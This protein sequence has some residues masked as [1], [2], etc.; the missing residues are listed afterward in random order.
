[1]NVRNFKKMAGCRNDKLVIFGKKTKLVPKQ[2]K[3][4]GYI[5]SYTVQELK[6]ITNNSQFFIIIAIFS[7]SLGFNSSY[8]VSRNGS[9]LFLTFETAD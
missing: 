9:V 5:K 8:R 3:T 1:M 2:K 4:S 7:H 6:I